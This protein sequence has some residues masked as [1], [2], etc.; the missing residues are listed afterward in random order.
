M[1]GLFRYL[2]LI[3]IG[4]LLSLGAVAYLR[5]PSGLPATLDKMHQVQK[6]EEENN[7]L[8][9]EIQQRQ[10]RIERLKTS[11]PARDR[12]IRDRYNMQKRNEKTYYTSP[13]KSAK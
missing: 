11:Q 5:A 12:E 7:R 9:E 8:R 10:D 13:D 3:L 1:R 4:A 2:S 6:M